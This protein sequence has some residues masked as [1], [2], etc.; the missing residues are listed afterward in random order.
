MTTESG[1]NQDFTDL[2]TELNH[3]KVQY[4][5]IG[6]HAMAAHGVPRATGDMD[7]F[8]AAIDAN[9]TKLLDALRAFGAPVDSH[10]V[11]K[12]SL[13][14]PGTIYQIGLPPKRID[15]ISRI[16]GV[17]FEEA[18]ES[19]I[20]INRSGISI[21]VIGVETLK[22]NKLSTGREKDQLDVKLIE[23]ILAD[24]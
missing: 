7:I 15:L 11:T 22:K 9:V 4:L 17:S 13:S 24:N 21:P 5:L 20:L 6:A 16:D 10:G 12:E 18:W 1:L 3:Y 8:Y 19:R 14:K 2:L 23:R